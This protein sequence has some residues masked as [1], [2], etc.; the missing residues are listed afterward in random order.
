MAMGEVDSHPAK[1]CHMWHAIVACWLVFKFVGKPNSRP[2]V[3]CIAM[4]IHASH[5]EIIYKWYILSISFCMFF[6]AG[7]QCIG[8]PPKWDSI[9]SQNTAPHGTTAPPRTFHLCPLTIVGKD[10]QP[11]GTESEG[12]AGDFC[13]CL[14]TLVW[15]SWNC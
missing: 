9:L 1:I 4:E 12:S 15:C 10:P 3:F 14:L 5:S 13:R 6:L 7:N 8:G 2:D 11:H